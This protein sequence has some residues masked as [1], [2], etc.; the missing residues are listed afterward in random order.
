MKAFVLPG[1]TLQVIMQHTL[2]ILLKR[3]TGS[4][5]LHCHFPEGQRNLGIQAVSLLRYQDL[6]KLGEVI[7]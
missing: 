4:F 1:I 5:L 3:S 2:V 7:Q 6:R